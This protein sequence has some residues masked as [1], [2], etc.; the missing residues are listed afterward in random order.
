MKHASFLRISLLLL[1]AAFGPTHAQSKY[2]T[3]T[4]KV[5]FFSA[6][7][8][9]DIEATTQQVAAVLNMGTGQLAFSLPM[10]S[11]VFKRTLM[12]EHFNENYVESDKF[13][14]ATF[15]GRFVGFE[16]AT[17]AAA[18]PHAAQV[19]GDLTLHG[20]TRH[21]LVP[22]TLELKG[23]QLLALATFL[24]AS[25]DYGIEIPLLVRNNIAKTVSVRVTLACDPVAGGTAAPPAH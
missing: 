12:Q 5:T 19:E 18:G 17:L 3:K 7:P 4:G 13:P 1:F 24:V 16:P 2:M 11:F 25:A 14:R 22:A 8:I 23:G 20:I 10:K 9:E 6:T 15:A 21:I